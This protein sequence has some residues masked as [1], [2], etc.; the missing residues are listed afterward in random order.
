[1]VS[2]RK[3]GAN[4]THCICYPAFSLCASG[5]VGTYPSGI[6]HRCDDHPRVSGESVSLAEG[7]DDCGQLYW[8]Y[9]ADLFGTHSS[10]CSDILG[11]TPAPG[12]NHGTGRFSG[13]L[14]VK[15]VD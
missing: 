11:C 3:M 6:K 1:M 14:I 4:T 2:H 7:Y 8:K 5:V 9:V 12:S 13:Q 10:G 15:W